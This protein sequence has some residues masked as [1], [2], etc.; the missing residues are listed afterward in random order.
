MRRIIKIVGMFYGIKRLKT[1][2]VPLK[3]NTLWTWS[4]VRINFL[5]NKK[6]SDWVGNRSNA[7]GRHGVKGPHYIIIQRVTGI[8]KE[9]IA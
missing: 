1:N 2:I 7:I 4:D 9:V 6:A 5:P 8:Y 3:P